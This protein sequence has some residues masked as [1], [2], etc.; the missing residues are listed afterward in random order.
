MMIF[1]DH[2]A[3]LEGVALRICWFML[4]VSPPVARLPPPQTARPTWLQ[5]APHARMPRGRAA[6]SPSCASVRV[7]EANPR[8]CSRRYL[9]SSF[10]NPT[11]L[12]MSAQTRRQLVDLAHELD[13]FLLC[14]DVYQ[15][16]VLEGACVASH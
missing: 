14:D 10:S 12:S 15:V 8:F 13:F 9:V 6:P 3:H 1:R 7:P 4:T 2:K 16:L 5:C 11:G